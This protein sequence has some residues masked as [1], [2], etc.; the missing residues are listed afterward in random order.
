LSDEVAA[1][2]VAVVAGAEVP[3]RMA[4]SLEL[5]A[6]ARDV[7]Q[8]IASRAAACV[9]ADYSNIALLDAAGASLRLFHGTFL[10]PALADRY[11]DVAIDAPYPIAAA[12]RSGKAVL[13]PDLEAYRRHFP[14]ILADTIA[15]G[16]RATASLPLYRIDG[17]PL[18]AIGFAWAEPPPFDLKL[19]TALEAVASLCSETVERARRYDEEHQV[20]VEL[21]RRMFDDLPATRVSRWPPG[22]FRPAVRHLS[23]VTGTKHCASEKTASPSS[24]GTWSDMAS[25][26]LP[27]WH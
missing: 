5:P 9:G 27:T 25:P 2:L 20:I 1:P 7:A 21:Q 10:D 17:A 16:V 11:I 14:E 8:F 24:S 3:D 26:R 18:G 6:T 12:V 13:L 22:T 23:A 15:A 19:E 4:P